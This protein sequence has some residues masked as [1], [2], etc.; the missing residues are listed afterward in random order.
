MASVKPVILSNTGRLTVIQSGDTIDPSVLPAGGGSGPTNLINARL[1]SV[2]NVNISAPGA[3]IDGVTA[4]STDLVLLKNQ[5]VPAENG[6]YVYNGA[7]S[8]MTRYSGLDSS[9]EAITGLLVSIAE[10]SANAKSVWML[11]TPQPITLNTTALTFDVLGG[12]ITTEVTVDFGSVPV[13]AKQFSVSLP[14]LTVNQR[15]M[16][17]S[18]GYTPSGVYFDE[19][20]FGVLS[21]VGKCTANDQLTLL[22]SSTSAISGQRIVRVTTNYTSSMAFVA[23][24]AAAVTPDY[25]ILN[26]N[27]I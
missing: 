10:G 23:A 27:I 1:A 16:C 18:S 17:T 21:W 24:S 3:T 25:M 14:G 20:E 22:G 8:A 19:Y 4:A 9:A 6:V 2:S 26:A 13:Y 15:V 12:A 5:T 11:T 7:A